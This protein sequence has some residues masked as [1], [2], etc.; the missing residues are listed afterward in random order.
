V[1]EAERLGGPTNRVQ[2]GDEISEDEAVS[3]LLAGRD[4]VVR[5]GDQRANSRLAEQLAG[6]AGEAVKDDPHGDGAL[7][8]FHVYHGDSKLACHAFY[9]TD[10]RRAA[11]PKRRKR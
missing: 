5:G 4:V 2:Y 8:H 9:E 1:H 3:R 10:R 11:Q 6:Q 7:P